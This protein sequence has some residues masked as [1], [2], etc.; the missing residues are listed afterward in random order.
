MHPLIADVARTL[1][2]GSPTGRFER[3][4]DTPPLHPLRDHD[5]P[6]YVADISSFH[7]WC[8]RVRGS[9]SRF[10]RPFGQVAVELAALYVMP[11]FHASTPIAEATDRT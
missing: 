5:S 6:L 9:L 8:G 11:A 10:N 2:Y 3:R 7:S 4:S 1:C